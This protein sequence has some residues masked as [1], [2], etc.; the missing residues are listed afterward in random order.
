[1]TTVTSADI[2]YPYVS[3]NLRSKPGPFLSS[4]DNVYVIGQQ[5]STTLRA[6]KA[7]D[8]TSSFAAQD[9]A[10]DPTFS[11]GIHCFWAVQDSDTIH[12][13][14]STLDTSGKN[15]AASVEYNTFSMSSD[16]WG[17][18]QA[19]QS[20]YNPG[21]ISAIQCSIAVR[22]TGVVVAFYQGAAASVMGGSYYRAVYNLR[23]SGTW[24]GPVEVDDGGEVH[25]YARTL[26]QGGSDRTH[27][28]Y[29]NF[30]GANMDEKS[31]SGSTLSSVHTITTGTI[32]SIPESGTYDAANDVLYKPM[33][34]KPGP[35]NYGY[36]FT[37]ASSA[38]SS[39]TGTQYDDSITTYPLYADVALDAAV[40]HVIFFDTGI[41]HDQNSAPT[42]W[43][44]DTTLVSYV[45]GQRGAACNVYTRAGMKY[46]AYVYF[47]SSNTVY[48]ELAL[49]NYGTAALTGTGSLTVSGTASEFG[50]AGLSGTGSLTVDGTHEARGA[51]SLSGTGSLTATGTTAGDVL[52]AADLTGTG[53][54][55]VAGLLAWYGAAALSGTGS[56]TVVLPQLGV[57]IISIAVEEDQA[58]NPIFHVEAMEDDYATT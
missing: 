11:T 33:I 46:L 34:Y 27:F 58:G 42:T 54:I 47:D 5:T 17:T 56:L 10:H 3:T 57:R 23:T 55:T 6:F 4:G 12:V 26:L 16:A 25:Y 37:A 29:W 39:W 36:M 53:S 15:P 52:G 45:A 9:T 48:S 50:E 49:G 20:A 41:K 40:A 19:V 18:P 38:T 14:Y 44:T 35:N 43:G 31:L 1:M 32:N 21:T 51:A 2:F 8:P 28:F 13:I 22:G 7:T 24:G 30:T